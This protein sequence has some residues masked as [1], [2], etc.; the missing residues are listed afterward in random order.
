[1]IDRVVG[2]CAWVACV[3]LLISGVVHAQDKQDSPEVLNRQTDAKD[4]IR[5][6]FSKKTNTSDTVKKKSSTYTLLPSAGYN[7]SVG[8]SIGVTTT[9][10][11]TF[12]DPR[13]TSF[14]VFNANAYT[15]TG[16]LS[17]F[18]I[19]HNAFTN[20][21]KFNIQGG[22]QVG[23][24]VA[25]D[26]GI[27]TGRPAI[28]E[29]SFSINGFPLVNNADV[30]SI[31]YNYIKFNER[32]Y[33][34]VLD[35]VYAGAGVIVNIYKNIDDERNVGPNFGT[36]NYRYSVINGYPTEGYS[37][38]GLLFNVAYNTRDH[39]NRPYQGM[40]I[41]LVLRLNQQWMGSDYHASQLKTELR[42]YWSLSK[43]KPEHILA[44]W[45]W[46]SY[47]LGGNLPYL[48]LTGTG[49]DAFSR[50]GRGYTIGRFKGANF[51][52][53]ELEYRFPITKNKLFSGV[54]FINGQTARNS[55]RD[56]Q[57]FQY[58]EPGAGV[59]LRL[60]FNKNSRSNLCIDYARGA[61][62]SSGIFL[63]LNEV[64]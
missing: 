26:Y 35:H 6:I 15:S 52:Y 53:S 56:I 51:F 10:G 63:G 50:L 30:F 14:S 28:G 43:K 42:K 23:N 57:L 64:F 36:H 1:L 61:Y 7:P 62:G 48:E 8:F 49:S 41:D 27:G 17:N 11:K 5:G 33:M 46:A 60:L 40:Y 45:M 47:L 32:I 58:I 9:T 19:E 31:Q 12:G 20:G 55:R 37:A 24:T 22:L 44:Y 29:G 25:L 18:E 4:V 39:V 16:G 59:G 54:T 34:E 38:N 3:L 13:T 21:D 2:K